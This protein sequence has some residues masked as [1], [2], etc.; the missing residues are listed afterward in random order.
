MMLDFKNILI[1]EDQ[2]IRTAL[3]KINRSGLKTIIVIDKKNKFKGIISDGDVRRAILKKIRLNDSVKKIYNRSSTFLFD[4]DYNTEKIKKIFFKKQIDIIPIINKKNKEVINL[5]KATDFLLNKSRGLDKR[6]SVVLMAGGLGKRLAPITNF[7]PKAMMP[8]NGKPILEHIIS[9]FFS[10]QYNNYF[11]CLNYKSEIIKSYFKKIKRFKINYIKENKPLGT[12]GV[13]RNFKNKLTSDF[14]L[15]N[16]D[17]L[18]DVNYDDILNFHKK[19]KNQITIVASEKEYNLQYG[20]CDITR[21]GS[22]VKILE[23]PSFD[24]IINAGLYVINKK[25]LKLIPK[26][27][28]D[29]PELIQNA[30]KKG[31]KI[32]VYFISEKSWIDIGQWDEFDNSR[33]KIKLF[34]KF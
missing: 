7:L 9:S 22:L 24:F 30:K 25:I 34:K 27:S 19:N 1:N 11:L 32:S 8:F 20:V 31:Y 12:C 2:T 13:L 6:N 16:C 17:V 23:K 14:F 33:N 5:I 15:T 28:Y 26:K 4:K 18:F 10:Y 21:K 29:V 3:E